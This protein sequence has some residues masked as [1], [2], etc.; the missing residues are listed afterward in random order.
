MSRRFKV[1]ISL[2]LVYLIASFC[3]NGDDKVVALYITSLLVCLWLPP[4]SKWVF[5]PKFNRQ[6]QS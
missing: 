5:D 6:E 1:L 3:F 4:V 2:T